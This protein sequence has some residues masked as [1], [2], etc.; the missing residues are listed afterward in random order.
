MEVW[1]CFLDYW[2]KAFLWGFIA[3]VLNFIPTI[4]SI[5]AVLIPTIFAFI[6]LSLI[7]DVLILFTLLIIIQF[8]L[9]N[10]VQPRMM[11]DKLN[12]S[13]FVVILSLVI[14][15]AMWGTIV[16]FL[17]VPLM[18]ILLIIFSQFEST[19][20]LAILISGDGNILRKS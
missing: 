5:I 16:M 3:F 20:K 8:V 6:Q 7:S 2:A 10:I 14:W 12:I 15:G 17:S 13:Q 18:V 1:D 4:G 9:G 19:K 11:G